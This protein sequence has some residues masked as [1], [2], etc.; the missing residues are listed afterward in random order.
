MAGAADAAGLPLVVLA[1]VDQLRPVA[2]ERLGLVGRDVDV[3]L[4]WPD[5]VPTQKGV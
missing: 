2:D 3:P 4:A 5:T 1:H